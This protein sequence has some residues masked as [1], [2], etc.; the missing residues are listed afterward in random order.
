MTDSE[1]NL[2]PLADFFD[3]VWWESA[4]QVLSIRR[5][6]PLLPYAGV[7]DSM[8]RDPAG[9]VRAGYYFFQSL[10]D[11][12]VVSDRPRA[13]SNPL[14]DYAEETAEIADR[15]FSIITHEY[16]RP[17][18][19]ELYAWAQRNFVDPWQVNRWRIWRSL[20][21]RLIGESAIYYP[22]VDPRLPSH[23]LANVHKTIH[24]LTPLLYIDENSTTGVARLVTEAREL[25]MSAFEKQIVNIQPRHADDPSEVDVVLA[26]TACIEQHAAYLVWKD[27][28][29]LLDE[30]SKNELV[31]WAKRQ[32]SV[33]GEPTQFLQSL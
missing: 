6:H 9:L 32:A 33:M 2:D 21:L 16:S 8:S 20:F 17:L 22:L 7:P 13:E 23:E 29:T 14:A 11:L 27:L 25:P 31:L 24:E 10:F 18:S 1:L 15:A 19:I 30:S 28:Q 26:V 5:C 12:A 3:R 4:F